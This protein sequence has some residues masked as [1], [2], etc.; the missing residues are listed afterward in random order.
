[1]TYLRK[2]KTEKKITNVN[3][4]YGAYILRV[5]KREEGKCT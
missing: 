5:Y 4:F 1:M 2:T 3:Y